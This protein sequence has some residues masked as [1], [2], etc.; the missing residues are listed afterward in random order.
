MKTLAQQVLKVSED[1]TWNENLNVGYWISPLGE[2]F[3]VD[4]NHIITIITNPQKF[5]LTKK[6]I[7]KV[8]KK[9]KEKIGSEGNAREELIVD[10]VNRGWIRV[11][12]YQ[13]YGDITWSINVKR[14]TKRVKDHITNFFQKLS[15]GT[16][17]VGG[18]VMIDSPTGVDRFSPDEITQYALYNESFEGPISHKLTFKKSV[19]DD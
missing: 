13:R 12:S 9:H 5:G 14:L 2:T 16:S 6:D 15:K 3:P 8:Y 17:Y 18:E 19:H 1:N 11:R 4:Q 7:Q 10:A